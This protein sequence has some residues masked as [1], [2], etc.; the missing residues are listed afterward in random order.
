MF[1]KLEDYLNQVR[2]N[3]DVTEEHDILSRVLVSRQ[4]V[5]QLANML[6]IRRVP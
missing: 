6:R 2:I 3:C 4:S 1:G 5:S